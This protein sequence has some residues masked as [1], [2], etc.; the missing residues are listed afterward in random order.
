LRV[1]CDSNSVR[2]SYFPISH[3]STAVSQP[4]QDVF[5]SR[6]VD[7]ST[8]LNGSGTGLAWAALSVRGPLANSANVNGLDRVQPLLL[9]VTNLG[10][11]R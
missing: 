9:Q 11:H 7:V 1:S 6:G 2:R 10:T 4:R 3:R 8:V 5:E